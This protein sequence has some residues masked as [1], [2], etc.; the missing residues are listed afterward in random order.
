MIEL[1]AQER[2]TRCDECIRMIDLKLGRNHITFVL[3]L[4]GDLGTQLISK[5]HL[6]G[7]SIRQGAQI[8]FSCP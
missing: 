6:Q 8:G 7:S 1:A 5:L 2:W 3:P 4:F